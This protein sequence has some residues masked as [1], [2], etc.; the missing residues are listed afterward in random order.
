VN[1]R[2]PGGMNIS[3]GS[4]VMPMMEHSK[5]NKDGNRKD[6]GDFHLMTKKN[7][8][9]KIKNYNEVD[10]EILF[11]DVN[12]VF[13]NHPEDYISKLEDLGFEYFDDDMEDEETEERNAK[14]GNQ[15]QQDLVDFFENRKNLTEEIFECFSDEKASEECNDALIRKYFRR[16]NQNLKALLIYGIDKYPGRIDLLSDLAFFHEFENILGMLIKYFTRACIEQGNL[17]AFSQLAKE[18]YYSTFPDGYDAYYALKE[19][20]EPGTEKRKIV[21]SFIAEKEKAERES[22]IHV[23]VN[24]KLS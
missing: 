6:R 1:I 14:P 2:Y 19:L 16:A 23:E 7:K 18:F 4:A 20:F 8:K 12:E 11:E 22:S 13:R 5:K 10:D 21:D 9:T 3:S 17:E 15:R 24:M